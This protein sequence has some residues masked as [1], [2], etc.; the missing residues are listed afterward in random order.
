[1]YL[2]QSS[3]TLRLGNFGWGVVID[4]FRSMA[5]SAVDGPA[6][7]STIDRISQLGQSASLS[8][9]VWSAR[10]RQDSNPV[11]CS[12]PECAIALQG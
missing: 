4:S 2:P 11:L 12:R 5:Q 1:M 3:Q 8:P 9:R 7:P 6:L 10:N